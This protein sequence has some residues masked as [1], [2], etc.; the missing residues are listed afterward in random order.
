[1]LTYQFKLKLSCHRIHHACMAFRV[2]VALKL[3][4]I[5]HMA[6]RDSLFFEHA[7]LED[8]EGR[9]LLIIHLVRK[10]E[11]TREKTSRQMCPPKPCFLLQAWW[12]GAPTSRESPQ[13]VTGASKCK[14]GLLLQHPPLVD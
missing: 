3:K 7:L 5:Q 10:V 12:I 9:I 11:Q 4:S 6:A 8:L 14:S 13:S 1:M 2:L